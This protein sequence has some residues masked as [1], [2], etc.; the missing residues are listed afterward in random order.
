MANIGYS[1]LLVLAAF[2]WGTTFVAQA[3]GN[4]AGPFVFT[5]VRNFL[6]TFLL[7]GLAKILDF[8]G[9][10][11]KKPQNVLQTK[12][13]WKAGIFCG[14]ALGFGTNFQQLGL[15]LG[16][17]AGK[18][19]FLTTCYIIL[20][21]VLSVFLGKKITGKIWFCVLLT[22]AGLYLLCIKDGFS[23]QAADGV[24]LL[25]ALS[26]AIQILITDRFCQE[27]DN[28]R[29][30]AIQCL[31]ACVVSSIPMLFVDLKLSTAGLMNA[32]EIYTHWNAWIPLLYA[33]VLSSGVAFTL[34]IVAQNKIRPT[35]ASLL[36][37]LESVF[38]VLGGWAV[39]NERLSFQEGVGCVLMF[40]AVILSQIKLGKK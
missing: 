13:L 22:L 10:S 2:I 20:V 17:S 39:L 16:C 23:I 32:V 11:P 1:L 15:F 29:L 5:F 34:Q 25:C 26:F 36:M 30:S 33:A 35:V 4:S 8:A 12:N 40:I 7:F 27:V 14:L 31:V 6:A 28:V 24:L 21:P 18:S 37:S 38:A 3:E 9:K 19:G